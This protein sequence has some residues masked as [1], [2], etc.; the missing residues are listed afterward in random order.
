MGVGVFSRVGLFSGEITVYGYSKTLVMQQTV[1]IK[2]FATLMA[3]VPVQE[4]SILTC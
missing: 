2:G 3:L 4:D 1:T